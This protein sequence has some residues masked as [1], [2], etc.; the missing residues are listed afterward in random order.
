MP[1]YVIHLSCARRA[2][3]WL[4]EMDAR[5]QNLFFLGNIIAD[6]CVD[7]HYTHFWNDATYPMLARRPDLNWFLKKYKDLLSEPYVLGY[8]T[9]LLL[10]YRFLDEYWD[11]HFRFYGSNREVNCLYQDVKYVEVLEQRKIYDRYDFFSKKWYYGDYDR[12][13]AYF[14]NKYKVQFPELK[15]SDVEW[16]QV[17]YITEIDWLYAPE[18]MR[19]TKTLFEIGAAEEGKNHSDEKPQLQIFVLEELETL[20]KETAKKVAEII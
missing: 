13:N 19:R 9:H 18:A 16:E 17:H 6:M 15:L 11:A 20:I 1:S 2:L 4:P 7:K 14:A 3:E 8:Y 5:E 12:M 10:D